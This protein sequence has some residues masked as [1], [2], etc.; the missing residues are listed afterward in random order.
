MFLLALFG[1]G[2]LCEN[3][4]ELI[5]GVNVSDSEDVLLN[6]AS[7]EVI[8]DG[9]VFHS[10]MK[11]RVSAKK[12]CSNVVAVDNWVFFQIQVM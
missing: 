7:D 2:G 10:R 5:F 3:V 9:N 8:V 12:C 11:N 1:P 4:P 6:V